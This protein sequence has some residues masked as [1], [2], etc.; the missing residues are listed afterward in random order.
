MLTP[1]IV[2]NPLNHN[3]IGVLVKLKPTLLS[4]LLGGGGGLAQS[5]YN[6][7]NLSQWDCMTCCLSPTKYIITSV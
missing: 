5:L 4:T 1:E 2:L 7:L 6:S 3:L